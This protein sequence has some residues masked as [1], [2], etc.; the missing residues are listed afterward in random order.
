MLATIAD[1]GPEIVDSGSLAADY[2]G[3]GPL[4]YLAFAA[5]IAF[6]PWRYAPLF[7]VALSAMFIFGGF[8]DSAFRGR[9]VTPGDSLYFGAGWLQ[10]LAF[11]AAIVF[12][13]A[14]VWLPSRY[15]IQ[16]L[17]NDSTRSDSWQEGHS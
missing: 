14:A 3:P 10:I 1:A 8:A 9:L 17:R 5:F 13:L 7:G 6:T 2:D 16:L 12:G 15:D 11:A 4:I